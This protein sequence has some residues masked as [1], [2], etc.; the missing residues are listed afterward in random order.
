MNSYN[1][2]EAKTH[3][4]ALIEAVQRGDEILITRYGRPSAKLVSAVPSQKITLGFRPINFSSDL[5]EPTD[6]ET[7]ALFFGKDFWCG[8]C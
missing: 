2:N 3:L 4:S 7:S 6:L 5:L 1:L 8:I